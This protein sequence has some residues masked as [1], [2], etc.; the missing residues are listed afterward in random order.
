LFWLVF[1]DVV[2]QSTHLVRRMRDPYSRALR[3][4]AMMVPAGEGRRML[5]ESL[6]IAREENA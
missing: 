1:E 5:E 3:L 4:L 2:A 6:T